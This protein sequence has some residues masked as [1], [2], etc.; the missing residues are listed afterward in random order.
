MLS[1]FRRLPALILAA[2]LVLGALAH[3]GHDLEHAACDPVGARDPHP[4]TACQ[5]MHVGAPVSPAVALAA[6]A[7]R[8]FQ[9]AVPASRP[10]PV[11]GLRTAAVPR[12]PP[13]A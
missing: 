8:S 13:A 1:A 12:A 2:V 11:A 3:F 9:P 10:A 4:C 7:A 5:V 6:P